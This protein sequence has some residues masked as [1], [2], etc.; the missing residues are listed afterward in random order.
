M[1]ADGCHRAVSS[2]MPCTW[3]IRCILP[4]NVVWMDGGIST[5]SSQGTR[6]ATTHRRPFG[7]IIPQICRADE[8]CRHC[9]FD[10]LHR[11]TSTRKGKRYNHGS[12]GLLRVCQLPA[13]VRMNR[14]WTVPLQSPSVDLRCRAIDRQIH[15]AFDTA[16][17]QLGPVVRRRS[18][19]FSQLACCHRGLRL[20]HIVAIY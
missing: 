8:S 3:A 7:D 1:F 12:P 18:H 9:N 6:R 2:R 15:E 4:H 5:V 10:R 19:R 14:R 13:R 11:F 16:A 17:D 20:T